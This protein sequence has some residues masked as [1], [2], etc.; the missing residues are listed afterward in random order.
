[1]KNN[2]IQQIIQRFLEGNASEEEKAILE[3]WY[4]KNYDN[5][6]YE[7]TPKEF[8][9]DLIDIGK[10]LP[11]KK[12]KGSI[13]YFPRVAAAVA[14]AIILIAF[15]FYHQIPRNKAHRTLSSNVSVEEKINEKREIKLSDSSKI[16]L[17]KNAHLIYP[18]VFN[19]TAREVFL[20]GEAYFDIKHDPSRPFIIHTGDV[21]TTVLGTAF[22]IKEDKK[23]HKITITVTRGKVRVSNGNQ[24]LGILTPNQQ[25]SY[26]IIDYKV[27]QQ[28]VDPAKFIAWQQI[29]MQFNNITFE[30]ATNELE[31]RF[32]LKI[33]FANP[34]LKGCR[35]SG[36]TLTGEKPEKVLNIICQFNNATYIKRPDGSFV[37]D[38][39]G[40]E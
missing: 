12:L 32:H 25:L 35:F 23:L 17:N 16:W 3:S 37:I 22:N 24:T 27:Y 15:L 11:L 8:A 19:S 28:T 1:M 6:P 36:A 18:K 14:A 5:S 30:E 39:Q 21:I 31:Q 34:K 20:T 10:E 13:I 29:D 33:L 2:E 9:D 4:S 38:G 40:C 7:L 26:N